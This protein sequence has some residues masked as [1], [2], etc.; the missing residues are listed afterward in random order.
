MKTPS[1]SV[2]WAVSHESTCS[3]AD[4]A[5]YQQRLSGPLLDRIDLYVEV[6]R[7]DYDKLSSDRLGS[8]SARIRERIERAREVQRMCFVGTTLLCNAD[9]GPKEVRECCALDDAGKTLLKTAMR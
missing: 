6:P 7:V 8:P 9:M 2:S 3:S 4:I 1:S 5:R